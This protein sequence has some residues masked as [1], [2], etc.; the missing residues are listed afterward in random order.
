MGQVRQSFILIANSI[1]IVDKLPPIIAIIATNGHNH[2]LIAYTNSICI[3]TLLEH[4]IFEARFDDT[5][6]IDLSYASSFSFKD[7]SSPSRTQ[8]EKS[9]PRKCVMLA[10]F[11]LRSSSRLTDVHWEANHSNMWCEQTF[12]QSQHTLSLSVT[13]CFEIESYAALF[14]REMIGQKK[15]PNERAKKENNVFVIRVLKSRIK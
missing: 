5:H 7:E 6:S 2:F 8:C 9:K 11:C 3:L 10:A 12:T 4:I 14:S 15:R 1:A 13:L